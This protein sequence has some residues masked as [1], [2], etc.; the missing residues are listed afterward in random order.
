MNEWKSRPRPREP[1]AWPEPPPPVGWPGPAPERIPGPPVGRG[2]EP[3][4]EQPHIL[5]LTE[6]GVIR[7]DIEAIAERLEA[8][9]TAMSGR[10]TAVESALA[11]TRDVGH[12]SSADL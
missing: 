2:R 1:G 5:I 10:I 4:H 11:V 8:A 12:D 7:G 6:L 3:L 9:L